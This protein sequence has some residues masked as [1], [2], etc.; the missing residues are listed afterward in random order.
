MSASTDHAAASRDTTAFDFAFTSIDG[1]P[2]PLAAWRGRALLI[3]NTASRCGFTG[4]YAGLQRLHE[5]YAAR[6]L[7]VLGVPSNDFGGQEPGSEADIKAFCGA[8]FAVEFQ[9]TG[10]THVRGRAAHPFYRWAAQA[11]GWAARPRWNFHKYLVAPDG[12]L[13]DWFSTLTQPTAHRLAAAI[14][15]VLPR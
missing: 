6:G 4:Q 3:V 14:E 7:T 2:L 13:A 5:T 11:R 8:R 15:H 12:R 10:K 9:L 1:A